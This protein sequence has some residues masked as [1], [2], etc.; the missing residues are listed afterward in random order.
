MHTAGDCIDCGMCV[1]TCPTGI[2][3][4]DGLQME[5]IHCAQC[6]DA[7]DSVMERIGKP[8]G[9][10]RYTSRE[11]LAG[12]TA[13][14]RRPRTMLYPAALAVFLGAFVWQLTTKDAADV[15]ILRS[16]GA[17]FATEADGRIANQV[18]IK[19]S[20]R[21]SR[22]QQYQLVV[23]GAEA[24]TVIAPVNPFP[25]AGGATETTSLFVLLPVD[26]FDDG[27]REI[28]IAVTDGASFSATFP[29]RLLGP[30][31]RDDDDRQRDKGREGR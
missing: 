19:I 1:Q 31:H 4:R 15:V 2:D 22:T 20:N 28:A 27:E 21:T 8:P 10:I 9:L 16:T 23:R 5:C 18:R 3:I 12:R 29:W 7:C 25:V 26:A 11:A 30:R 17:P 14:L 24:G 6:I 13:P